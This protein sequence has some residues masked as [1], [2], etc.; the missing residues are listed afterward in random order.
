MLLSTRAGGVG[1]NLTAADTCIIFDSDWNPQNDIQAQARCHRIGQTKNV[2]IFRLITKNTY[3]QQMF[4]QASLK[5][6]LEQAVLQGVTGT[7]Q[8][9]ME[10]SSL[11]KEVVESLLQKGAYAAFGDDDDD[12]DENITTTSSLED[13]LA[14]STVITHDNTGSKSFA[15]NG[16][17]SK[18]N[19]RS[20]V[21]NCYTWL[22]PLTELTLLNYFCS[23]AALVLR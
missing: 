10:A 2:K 11:S 12:D 22:H 21:R 19:E 16:T 4:K 9:Q 18:V 6:G 3:E 1:I 14:S 17:F 23:L 20:A 5:M 8:K 7:T 13:I 15:A